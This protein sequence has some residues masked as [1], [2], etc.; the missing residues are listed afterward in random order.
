ML[1]DATP[2]YNR[3]WLLKFLALKTQSRTA[4]FIFNRN[5]LKDNVNKIALNCCSGVC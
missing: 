2:T 5:N 4:L 1:E 3:N